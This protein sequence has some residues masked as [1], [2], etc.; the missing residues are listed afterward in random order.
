MRLGA[1]PF[2]VSKL[3]FSKQYLPLAKNLFYDLVQGPFFA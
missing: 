2:A 3:R 1:L